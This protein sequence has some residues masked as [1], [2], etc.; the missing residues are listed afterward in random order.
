M[1][2]EPPYVPLTLSDLD[3][4]F[5]AH[6]LDWMPEWDALPEEWRDPDGWEVKLW[7]DIFF[8]S[9]NEDFDWEALK[10]IPVEGIDPEVAWRHLIAITSSYA[11]K[12]QHK[13]AALAFLTH[14]WFQGASWVYRGTHR[15]GGIFTELEE[16]QT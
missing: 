7:R 11:P 9:S 15:A 14:H 1:A 10:L 3:L 16:E 2:L 13:E 8:R 4:A 6:A 5:P 12:H